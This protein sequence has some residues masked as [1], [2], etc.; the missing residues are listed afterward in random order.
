M[1]KLFCKACFTACL[2]AIALPFMGFAADEP[3]PVQPQNPAQV[4]FSKDKI[5]QLVAPIALYPDALIAQMLMASTYPAEIVQA[6]KW[7][8]GNPELRPEDMKSEMREKKWDT[9]VKSLITYPDVLYRMD[10]NLDWTKD[11]G[12]AVLS[13]QK[14]VLDA[15]QVMRAKAKQAGNLNSDNNQNVSVQPDNTQILPVNN[16]QVYVPAYNPSNVYGSGWGGDGGGSNCYYPGM[17]NYPGGPWAYNQ[18]NLYGNCN[19]NNHNLYEDRNAFNRLYNND[20]NFKQDV[21]NIRQDWQHNPD[22]RQGVP[23]NNQETNNRYAK[24]LEAEH[25][26]L[27][28]FRGYPQQTRASMP[29]N[30]NIAQNFQRANLNTS[31][32][33]QNQGNQ[34]S[35]YNQNQGRVNAFSGC[36]NQEMENAYRNR[37]AN[38][39]GTGTAHHS[40]SGSHAGGAGGHSSGGGHA[41]GGGGAHR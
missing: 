12:D 28:Q 18:N 37:G 2:V 8:K 19:W 14:D 33:V 34:V 38:S 31:P 22:H 36:S 21:N 23:Y 40:G 26:N 1:R 20:P 39:R 17:N 11:L 9:S 15:V 4:Y 30:Q 27:N 32:N 5:E 6:S 13:Q 7:L 24:Q 3:Q 16:D 41:S 29:A 35:S 10:S 25:S